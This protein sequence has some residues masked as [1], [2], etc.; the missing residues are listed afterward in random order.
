[1]QRTVRFTVTCLLL[2]AAFQ[3][4][5]AQRCGSDGV[6]MQVLGSGGPE[7]TDQRASSGYLV[8]QDGHARILV[9]MGPGSMLRYEQSGARI[10]DLDVV[11]LTHLHVDHS[12]DLPTLIKA[13][14]FTE[15]TRSLPIFGPT[16]NEVMP[17]TIA[18]VEAL[19]ASPSG[20][21]RYRSGYLAGDEAFSLLPHNVPA[22][23]MDVK[24]VMEGKGYKITAVPVNHGPIPALAWRIDIAGRS[25]VFSG[26]MNGDNHT[27]PKLAK[28]ADL[29]VAHHAIPQNA[30]GVAR[31]LH[32]PPSVIGEIAGES[33]VKQLVLS[34]RMNRTFGVE[35]ESEVEIRKNYTGPLTFA[36]DRQCFKVSIQY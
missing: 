34:H 13:A 30:T 29:L 20:A 32:M 28:G 16:G 18:F 26:D 6:W 12:A 4:H 14:F 5:A 10:E 3:T 24:Q 31:N 7:M 15:R 11:L 2:V 17:D 36:E 21:Y 1:M 23:G 25:L 35:S 8:W 9:D 19:F 33:N 27:L 22:V